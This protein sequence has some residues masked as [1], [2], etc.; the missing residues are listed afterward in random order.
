MSA[1]RRA[2][3]GYAED[4]ISGWLKVRE[5]R[6]VATLTVADRVSLA[7]GEDFS[8]DSVPLNDRSGYRLL[9]ISRKLG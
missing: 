6:Q 1:A 9:R 2:D 4:V 5:S 8:I 7:D 3:Y